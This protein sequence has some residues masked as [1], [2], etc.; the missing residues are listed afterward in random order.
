MSMYH[1]TLINC[2]YGWTVGKERA[3][4]NW[5]NVITAAWLIVMAVGVVVEIA[6]LNGWIS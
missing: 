3:P 6:K 4:I 5:S 2:R 1:Q